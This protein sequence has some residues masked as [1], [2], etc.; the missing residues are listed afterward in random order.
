M[1]I[2]ISR[3]GTVILRWHSVSFGENLLG[4]DGGSSKERNP[5]QNLSRKSEWV[6]WLCKRP[7]LDVGTFPEKA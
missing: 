4:F 6:V 7:S 2:G 3:Y 1:I 5:L